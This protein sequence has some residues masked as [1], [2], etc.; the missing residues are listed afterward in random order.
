M[1]MT[2]E[3]MMQRC[4]QLASLGAGSVA[5]NPMVGAVLVHEGVIIGE[6]WHE[7]F[8][9]AHAEVNCLESVGEKDRDL[10]PRSTLYVNLEPCAHYGKT[11]PCSDLIIRSRIPRVMV[12][13]VDPFA[14]VAGKG[15]ARMKEAGIEVVT[16][17]LEAACRHL[18]RRFFT[19]HE[20]K[21]PYLIL[22][23]AS[24]AD[25]FMAL[26]GPVPLKI[27][28]AFADRLV[29]RWRSEE[30]AILVGAGT[31]IADDPALTNRLWSGPS[32]LRIL[33]DTALRA[34]SS[35][36]LFDGTTPTWVFNNKRE[37]EKK[38]IRWIRV[39]PQ[40]PFLEEVLRILHERDILSV[41][42]EGGLRTLQSFIDAGLWDEA[43]VLTGTTVI[44]DGLRTPQ[45]KKFS[46]VRTM[47]V[48]GDQV[49]Y[50]EHG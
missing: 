16:G 32:P 3:Q 21:R 49:R 11:P 41:L 25:G 27:T 2:D 13:S 29:H 26:P 31:A 14:A 43:R 19:F 1:S 9:E 17:V 39:G 50:I 23:W 15:I 33:L 45:L 24:T 36:R 47:D 38:N 18:N 7:R 37:D 34:P 8:G 5:P 6:G 12:G 42:V 35:L 20:L 46:L 28:N 48:E 22:K 4:L 40:R 10:I 44:G 30:A